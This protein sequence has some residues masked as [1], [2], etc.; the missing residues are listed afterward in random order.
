MKMDQTSRLIAAIGGTVALIIWLVLPIYAF[1]IIIP[2]FHITGYR[3]AMS[4][5]QITIIFLIFPLLMALVPLSGEKRFCI[6]AG[7]L[8][9]IACLVIL[10]AKKEIIVNGNMKWL[11]QSA[12]ALISGLGSSMGQTITESNFSSYI[13]VACDN[14]LIGGLGL[15][16]NLVLSLVYVIFITLFTKDESHGSVASG[17]LKK[18]NPVMQKRAIQ[19]IQWEQPQQGQLIALDRRKTCFDLLN[20]TYKTIFC[21]HSADRPVLHWICMRRSLCGSI[22]I[23]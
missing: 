20:E 9:L 14:F 6:W 19:A 17:G 7:V 21:I 16:I 23:G 2:L 15:W 1:V 18:D 13:G 8:N 5:N 4:L 11:F 22:C 12:G 3:L 10:L